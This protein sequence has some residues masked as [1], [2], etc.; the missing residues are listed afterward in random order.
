[1]KTHLK[2]EGARRTACGRKITKTLHDTTLARL[3]SCFS[4]KW[5]EQFQR[6]LKEQEEAR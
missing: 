2:K 3:T 5:T 6:T 4:C 1:M